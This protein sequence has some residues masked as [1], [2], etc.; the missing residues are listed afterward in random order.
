LTAKLAKCEA[1]SSPAFPLLESYY[2]NKNIKSK[3]PYRLFGKR[4]GKNKNGK[5]EF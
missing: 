2:K 5:N 3:T 1:F 4:K